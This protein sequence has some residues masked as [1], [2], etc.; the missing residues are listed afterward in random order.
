MRDIDRRQVMAG[1]VS[2]ALAPSLGAAVRAKNANRQPN[3]VFLMADDMGYA[4]ISCNGRPDFATPN[5]DGIARAGINLRQAYANSAV[6]SASRCA[7]MTGRYQYR[8]RAGLEEP[9]AGKDGEVI[10]LPPN[11]PTLPSMLRKAGYQ[12]MLIGKWHLGELPRFG[13][14]QSGYDH[15]FGF[16]G[17]ALDYFTHAGVGGKADLWDDDVPVERNGYL[18]QMIGARAVK[19]IDAYSKTSRPFFLSVHFNAPHWPWEGPHDEAEAQRLSKANL[20]DF[21]GGSQATYRAMVQT[22]DE[23]IGLIVAELEKQGLKDD[24]IVIFTS[25]NGGERFADTWPFSGQKTELLEGGLRV[26]ALVKWPKV[27]PAGSVNEQVMITMDWVATLLAAAKGQP[28]GTS[29]LDG[30]DI[31]P[32]LTGK[33]PLQ[34]RELFWRY[35]ANHQR[36]LRDGDMKYL[37]IGSHEYLFNV[38]ADPLERANLK[39]R[40]PA[41]FAELKAKWRAWNKDMLPEL[42]ETFTE[43][44][45]AKDQA[46]HIG[47][48][49]TDKTADG[50]D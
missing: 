19:A 3:I 31:L 17:G 33:A 18:T 50:E 20:R 26:P 36:A 48:E 28:D 42:D 40:Q 27:L 15:F 23:Q 49:K 38:V 5:I 8:Y 32:I 44:V 25:D 12:T 1:G 22:M 24:T 9:I 41:L 47:A 6:C 45:L 46:D 16:R 10:G 7:L 34:S 35:K 11:V 37:K 43:G 30:V 39:D 2:L 21:D 14:L 29:P 4:D 13:P